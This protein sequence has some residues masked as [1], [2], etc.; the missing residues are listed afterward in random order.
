M[1]I[2][3]NYEE[4]NTIWYQSFS[5]D[6]RYWM[7]TP[8]ADEIANLCFYRS[9][10]CM[11]RDNETGERDRRQLLYDTMTP[12]FSKDSSENTINKWYTIIPSNNL[13]FRRAIKNLCNVYGKAPSRTFESNSI[14]KL[15]TDLFEEC[16]LDSS[17]KRIHELAKAT[18]EVAVRPI[19]KNGALELQYLTPD[20]YRVTKNPNGNGEIIE[21][22]IPF[23]QLLDTA[24]N[25]KEYII[26]FERWT[27]DTYEILDD[28]YRPTKQENTNNPYK[29][30][31]YEFLKLQTSTDDGLEVF[32]GTMIELVKAQLTLNQLDFLSHENL[33]KNGFSLLLM[34]N[35]DPEQDLQIGAG[36]VLM[37]DGIK[38]ND[39]ALIPPSAEYVT[40]SILFDRIEELKHVKMK[41]VLRAMGLPVSIIEDSP[42]FASGVAMKLD[43]IE[44]EEMRQED[45]S[46]LRRYERRLVDL[47]LTVIKRDPLAVNPKYRSLPETIDYTIDYNEIEFDTEPQ[48]QFDLLTM[49]YEKG[50]I[51]IQTYV[52]KVSNNDL[53]KTE[54]DAIE[55]MNHNLKVLNDISGSVQSIESTGATTNFQ[56][57]VSNDANANTNIA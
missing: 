27:K 38:A 41:Q 37:L 35:C 43:R 42:N 31:P 10:S 51:P 8:Y 52:Q 47:I 6:L 21:M 16:E 13:F 53:I 18:N 1:R 4:S 7:N 11:F 22:V 49:Q 2:K 12:F 45:V 29:R 55:Y 15:M 36:A 25:K 23:L 40:P 26:N 34:T 5:R 30:I 46:K 33:I 17:M 24:N 3:L 28:S 50:L 56:T 54:K 19:F 48:A 44:L 20:K 39:D 32:G 57:T 9:I 14:G